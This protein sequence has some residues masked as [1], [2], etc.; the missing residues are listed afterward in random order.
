MLQ[1]KGVLSMKEAII[2]I[3]HFNQVGNVEIKVQIHFRA[4]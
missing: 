3:E 4:K 1:Q 2:A